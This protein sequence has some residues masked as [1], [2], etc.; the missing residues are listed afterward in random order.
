MWRKRWINLLSRRIVSK[1]NISVT[2]TNLIR[3][4]FWRWFTGKNINSAAANRKNAGSVKKKKEVLRLSACIGCSRRLRQD[5][6]GICAKGK[7]VEIKSEA[8][9][10]AKP[11][12]DLND[13]MSRRANRNRRSDV[14]WTIR[15]VV[16]NIQSFVKF[17]FWQ[18]GLKRSPT[19]ICYTSTVVRAKKRENI[20]SSLLLD[21]TRS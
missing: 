8:S 16:E 9:V 13:R 7:H 18:W 4:P 11:S 1:I 12:I 21:M 3:L 17:L 10:K 15:N 5:S 6:V 19:A 20:C 2:N 14:F